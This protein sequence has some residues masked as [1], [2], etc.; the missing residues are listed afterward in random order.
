[1]EREEGGRGGMEGEKGSEIE[2]REGEGQR[3]RRERKAKGSCPTN[4]RARWQTVLMP[5][6]FPA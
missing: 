2:E 1:M 4:L 6:C 3:G 5:N